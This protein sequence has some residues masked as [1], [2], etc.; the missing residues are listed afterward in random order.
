MTCLRNASL[1]LY[2]APPCSFILNLK[3][4]VVL[5]I[6]RSD[7]G[8][9]NGNVNIQNHHSEWKQPEM[10]VHTTRPQ[11]WPVALESS[12]Q[13]VGKEASWV[14]LS[15]SSWHRS[16]DASIWRKSPTYT[17][18]FIFW[19][20]WGLQAPYHLW[21]TPCYVAQDVLELMTLL[22]P[23]PECWDYRCA[24]L[25]PATM[26]LVAWKLDLYCW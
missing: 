11:E 18:R 4:A 24:P 12:S 22:P 16:L 25:R 20:Y 10:R 1:S 23:P 7:R 26:V 13:P 9:E 2:D 19:W 5:L 6:I 15:S 21:V 8:Q 17:L 14:T 3:T